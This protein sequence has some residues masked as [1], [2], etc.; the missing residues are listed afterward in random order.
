MSDFEDDEDVEGVD[1]SDGEDSGVVD[2]RFLF[3]FQQKFKEN[4]KKIQRKIQRKS[5]KVW[6]KSYCNMKGIEFSLSLI[7]D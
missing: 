2:L 4:S 3:L 7:R 6:I 1:F 5:F